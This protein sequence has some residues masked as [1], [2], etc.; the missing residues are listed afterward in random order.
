MA[1]GEL[2]LYGDYSV[3]GINN[4]VIQNI[5]LFPHFKNFKVFNTDFCLQ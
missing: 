4:V 3:S 5:N 2:E 1:S